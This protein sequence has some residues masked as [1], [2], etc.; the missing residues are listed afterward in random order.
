[1]TIN[2]PQL[3]PG[4]AIQYSMILAQGMM[5]LAEQTDDDSHILSI[6]YQGEPGVGKSAIARAIAK[7]LNYWFEDIRANMMNPDDAGGTR[8]QDLDS[9]TTVWFPPFWMPPAEGGKIIGRDGKE[10]DGVVLFFDELASADDRVRK[11][12]F[13]VF[14]D[15]ALNGRPLPR[16]AIVLAAGNEAETGTMICELDN[17]TRTRFVT[18][19]VIAD[20][21]SWV[22][23]Y[24]P[25]ASIDPV[26]ISYLKQNTHRFCETLRAA[27]EERD[28]YGNPRNFEHV[29]SAQRAIMRAPADHKDEARVAALE[30]AVAGKIGNELAAEYMGVFQNVAEM[31]NLYD[32]RKATKEERKKLWPKSIGQ[33]YALSHSMMAWPTDVAQAKEIFALL[34]EMPDTDENGLPFKESKAPIREV[35]M[36]RLKEAGVK[37]AEIQRHFGAESREECAE[38]LKRPLIVIDA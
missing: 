28:L 11:P 23:Q 1:M 8:M 27:E 38:I 34:K 14:L 26:T 5:Q 18:V 16:N 7:K 32:I 36:Q 20:F 4:R 22:V 12:L 13:G 21:D 15:R 30:M 35:V 24:A 25:A 9:K 6:Y 19:K 33:L 31:A 10:Y 29:S 3:N 17:A 37:D 2:A